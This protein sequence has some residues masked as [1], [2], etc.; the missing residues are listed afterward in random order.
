MKV[1]EIMTTPV[2]SAEPET[3]TTDVVELLSLEWTCESCGEP[4]RGAQPPERCPRCGEPADRF[5]RQEQPPG[6]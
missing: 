6:E 1:K 2:V 3:P 4:V 5:T